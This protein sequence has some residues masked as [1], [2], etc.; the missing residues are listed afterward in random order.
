M[1]IVMA[2]AVVKRTA[3]VMDLAVVKRTAAIVMDLAVVKEVF[4]VVEVPVGHVQA[5]EYV[6]HQQQMFAMWCWYSCRKQ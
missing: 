3:I 2:L 4:V 6:W 5:I 1:A